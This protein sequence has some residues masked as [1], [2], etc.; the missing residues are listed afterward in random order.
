MGFSKADLPLHTERLTLRAF[1]KDDADHVYALYSNP[2]IVRYLYSDVMQPDRLGES[3]KRR[4]KRPKLEQEGDILELAADLTA[5]G[6]F[7]G[8]MTF[9]YRSTAHQRGE[10][11]YTVLPKFAGQGF[12]TEGARALLAIGFDRLNL[13]RMEARCDA[14]NVASTRVMARAG[15]RYE[16]LIRENEFVKGEWTD[17]IVYGM[18]AEDWAQL[19]NS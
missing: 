4:L 5:T 10:L 8:A 11:G 16:A 18:L 14:R 2:D 12:A 9:M 15:L 13:H 7:V 19:K 3:M 17:E 1:R 6:E